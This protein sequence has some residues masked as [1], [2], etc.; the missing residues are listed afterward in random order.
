MFIILNKISC[1]QK[2]TKT[3]QQQQTNLIHNASTVYVATI[4]IHSHIG[5]ECVAFKWRYCNFNYD[6]PDF[7]RKNVNEVDRIS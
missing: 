2:K 6:S 5:C 3:Q 4:R 1:G 7:I